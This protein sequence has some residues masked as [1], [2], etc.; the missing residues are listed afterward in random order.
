MISSANRVDI[1]KALQTGGWMSEKELTWL[2]ERAQNCRTIVE[3]GSYHGRSTRALA[4]NSPTD[5][6]IWA[7]DP[8]NGEY[9]TEE[10]MRVSDM[11]TYCLP[12][13]KRNL[14]DHIETG[15]VLPVRNFSYNFSCPYK[16]DLVFIDGDHRYD[17]VVKDIKKALELVGNYGIIAGHDYGHP[18]WP[19][20]K[21][22]VDMAFRKVEVVD[23][24]WN[25]RF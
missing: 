11:D 5:C 4:D 3:F 22:A 23:T 21:Q 25:L 16:I 17:T 6:K 1:S 8:W 2:A 20:V 24:I 10:G 9:K 12:Q 15:K 7:V 13:F 19:G 18:L 14:R